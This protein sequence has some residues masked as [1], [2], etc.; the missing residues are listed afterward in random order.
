MVRL[1]SSFFRA[2]NAQI[3][4]LFE[5]PGKEFVGYMMPKAKG[6]E[7]QKSIFIKPLFL[8]NFPN[9]K[10]R[11]TVELC[12]TILEKIKYLH[13]RNIVMGDIN[14][15]NILVVSPKEVYFVDTDSYQVEDFPWLI[16]RINTPY[17]KSHERFN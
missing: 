6:K 5:I 12:I 10:K 11:D 14:P 7:L 17:H 2:E 13:D 1:H 15:A 3:I 9:W 4:I 16:Y 8:K